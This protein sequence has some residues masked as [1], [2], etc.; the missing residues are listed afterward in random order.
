[1]EFSKWTLAPSSEKMYEL[2]AVLVHE[3]SQASSGHYYVYIHLDEHWYRFND[4]RVEF[5]GKARAMD[6][7]F[8]GIS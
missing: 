7:N 2:Y 1:M 6:Y 5:V 8:G 4:E 3:G